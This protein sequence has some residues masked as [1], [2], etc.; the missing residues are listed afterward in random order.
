M[1]IKFGYTIAY[2]D[3]VQDELSFFER[4][5]G[6]KSRF[7]HP[8]GD[9]GELDT[10]NTILAFA[11]HELGKS[12]L[13]SGYK[14]CEPDQPLGVEIAL[15]T[16]DVE[17]VHAKALQEGA[18]E[19]SAPAAKPWGQRVSYVISPAGVLLEICSPMN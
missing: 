16:N 7:L 11:S 12:N 5:F 13:P 1:T 3:N 9:Y 18:K 4:A 10:G 19:M 14:K 2:V 6:T 17:A 15:V 8:S